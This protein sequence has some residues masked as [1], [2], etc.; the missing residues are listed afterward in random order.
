V[1]RKLAKENLLLPILISLLVLI[2]VLGYATN[3]IKTT[4][5]LIVL[6]PGHGGSDTGLLY[7]SKIEEKDLM[8]TLA[9]KTAEIL[10][11]RYN[12]IL[13]RNNDIT[14]PQEQRVFVGN[15]NKADL[16]I[17]LHLHKSDTVSGYFY[18]FSLPA[19]SSI[20][21]KENFNTWRYAPMNQLM[22]SKSLS[23]IFKSNFSITSS[24]QIYIA[25]GLPL[26]T[27]EG[28]TMP[29]VQIEPL[30]ISYFSKDP[31]EV[32]TMLKTIAIKIL[33]SIDLFFKK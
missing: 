26:L 15:K 16:Y 33:N 24:D 2:P 9:K 18:Y 11:I 22:P 21:K 32:E 4:Q 25:N 1:S 13:T 19:H 3:N 30:S 28:T 12:V 20:P 14:I 8:L 27:L 17:S 6:D 29:A 23:K 5:K 10:E 31:V 7:S